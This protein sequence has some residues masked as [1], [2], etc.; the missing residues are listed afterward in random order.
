[1]KLIACI[2]I[3]AAF[4]VEVAAQHH[5]SGTI[6][7]RSADHTHSHSGPIVPI[8]SNRVIG[9]YQVTVW[10][11]PGTTNDQ[12]AA[13]RFW[14]TLH[15]ADRRAPLPEETHVS[16]AVTPADR[17]G[18]ARVVPAM[19]DRDPSTFFAAVVLDHEGPFC[20]H[21]AIA[22][23]LGIAEIDAAV[24]AEYDQRP[25]RWLIVLSVMPFVLMGGLWIALFLRRRGSGKPAPRGQ[26]A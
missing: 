3:A 6:D 8:V 4:T 1:M 22:G 13:G 19:R 12:T 16:V 2:A 20:V 15:P 14:V 9:A 25:G 11:D 23:P 24:E 5:G 10:S 17:S 26:P 18:P 21:V 7:E